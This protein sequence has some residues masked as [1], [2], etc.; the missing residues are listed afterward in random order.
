VFGAASTPPQTGGIFG[1]TTQPK[2]GGLF[3]PSSTFGSSAPG[4]FG[5]PSN[6]GFGQT[7]A[8]AFSSSSLFGGSAPQFL[9]APTSAPAPVLL[10]GVATSP[11][12]TLPAAP[13]LSSAD[14]PEHKVGLTQRP[15][16]PMMGRNV[17]RPTSVMTPRSITP[18]AGVRLR[19][20]RPRSASR[21]P[22]SGLD[23]QGDGFTEANGAGLSSDPRHLF[24]RDPLPS[25]TGAASTSSAP[26]TGPTQQQEPQQ[27]HQEQRR[28]GSDEI[29]PAR[30][31]S[32]QTVRPDEVDEDHDGSPSPRYDQRNTDATPE[33]WSSPSDWTE[34][35][36]QHSG[37]RGTDDEVMDLLPRLDPRSDLSLKPSLTQL[38]A[39]A[40]SDPSSLASVSNFTI[41]RPGIGSVC[42]LE[43][44]DVRHAEIEE[45]VRLTKGGVEVYLDDTAK[46]PVGE[47]FNRPARITL[48][49]VYKLDSTTRRQTKDPEA[50]E[51]FTI[52]LKKVSAQQGARFVSYKPDR[53]E[54]QF[55]V[56][57][58]SRYGLLDDSDEEDGPQGGVVNTH[59]ERSRLAQRLT[60]VAEDGSDETQQDEVVDVELGDGSQISA[61]NHLQ[62]Q[63]GQTVPTSESGR[64]L[65]V[66]LPALLQLAPEKL[67]SMRQSLFDK[68]ERAEVTAAMATQRAAPTAWLPPNKNKCALTP[69]PQADGALAELQMPRTLTAPQSS[70]GPALALLAQR[71]VQSPGAS[72]LIDLGI[73]LGDGR[74]AGWGPGGCFTQTGI[75]GRTQR[76]QLRQI[77]TSARLTSQSATIPGTRSRDL[78][79]AAL[80]VHAQYSSAIPGHGPQANATGSDSNGLVQ[81][82]HDLPLWSLKCG[83]QELQQLCLRFTELCTSFIN[84]HDLVAGLERS[85]LQHEAWTWD[86]VRVLFETLPSDFADT[87]QD[88]AHTAVGTQQC[89]PLLAALERRAALSHWL[90]DFARSHVETSLCGGATGCAAVLAAL[91]GHQLPAAAAVAATAGDVRLAS[92]IAQGSNRRATT[93]EVASQLRVWEDSGLISHMELE[94]LQVYRILGGQL[95]DVVSTLPGLPWR[96]ALGMHLWYGRGGSSSIQEALDDYE[97]A[98]AHGAAPPPL[99]LHAERHPTAS[100]GA[101]GPPVRT[102]QLWCDRHA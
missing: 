52:K 44:V 50:I 2:A 48:L 24:V 53:G 81:D 101:T 73:L 11:Y 39:M 31:A 40:A 59:T 51:R 33:P 13:Q 94:R 18:R 56:D 8:L 21:A 69:A 10:P 14:P 29:R 49:N 85:C 42:W 76:S 26:A 88:C 84:K 75:S 19:A 83:R 99:P 38:A 32:P 86:L 61:D 43:E 96:A 58:F 16:G 91:S 80:K 90:Q 64:P 60:S 102:L 46:P 63:P 55:E 9:P 98:V 6:T 89:R 65:P 78:L 4:A 57:H 3:A 37:R 12:G 47:G 1:G 34:R 15:L 66:M 92:I 68:T 71:D 36:G 30:S 45:L 82:S 79:E 72:S 87:A 22:S 54:W 100:Q 35:R 74:R 77:S 25:T 67:A 5:A 23:S 70:C 28:R 27:Q 7:S 95:D 17:S 41:S 62:P 20:A 97:N 93:S